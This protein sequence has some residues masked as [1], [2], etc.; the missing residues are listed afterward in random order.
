LLL[1]AGDVMTGTPISEIE[2]KGAT[3]GALFEMMNLTRY[4]AWTIGTTISISRR[5]ISGTDWNPKMPTVS[6]NL[7]DTAGAFPF[8]N[9][10]YVIIERSGLRIGIIGLISRDLFH[11]TNTKNLTGLK[12]LSPPEVTQRIIDKI[13]A[14]TDLI[15]ALS[16]EGVDDDS[17]LAASTHGLG[18]LSAATAT[19]A[20]RLQN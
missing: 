8:G 7:T 5:I 10:E 17:I 14:E 1:D 11:L 2:Y 16:H 13:R 3:G 6:A 4:D 18:S 20:S 15:V 9:K 12:V 19:P